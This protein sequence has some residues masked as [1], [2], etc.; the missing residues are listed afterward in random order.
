MNDNMI[1]DLHSIC[2][3]M[4]SKQTGKGAL[5]RESSAV[6]TDERGKTTPDMDKKEGEGGGSSSQKKEKK[7]GAFSLS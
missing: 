7:S 2:R 6:L 4:E 3:E 5:E 1:A